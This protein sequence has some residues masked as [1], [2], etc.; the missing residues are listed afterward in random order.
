MKTSSV[1]NQ[2]KRGNDGKWRHS[3]GNATN[4]PVD[5]SESSPLTRRNF[6]GRVG[7]VATLAIAASSIPLEPLLDDKHSVAEAAVVGYDPAARAAAGHN[8]R[9]SRAEA[10]NI[11]VGVQP[12]NGDTLS[13]TDFSG[14]FSKGLQHD[15]LGVPNAASWLSLKYALQSGRHSDYEKIIV[16]T[17]GGGPNSRLNGPQGSLAF[18]LEGLDSHAVVI[19]PAP[20]VASAQTAAEAIE[21]YWGALLADIPFTQY[22]TNSL[23][24]Q[25]VRDMNKLS[26]VKPNSQYPFPVTPQNLFR[27]QFFDGDG[28]VLGPYISQFLVQPTFYGAQPLSQ[29]YQT[30]LPVG[31]GGSSFMTSVNEYQT[32]QNGGD[33]GRQLVFDST[34][35]FVRNGRDLAAYTHVDVLYQAY[36]VAF[37]VLAGIGAPPNP[38]NPYTHSAAEK[39]FATLGGPDV[40]GSIA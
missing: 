27:G 38:G 29:Q 18:D 35:R 20:S 7:G 26:A 40:A 12:D 25:A 2:K 21:H 36:F 39:A 5:Q 8:Y 14:S 32:V 3:N 24:A 19:P 23:V 16:G 33:S 15:G 37:L 4:V 10:D 13:F 34:F 28:N 11:N 31:N 9:T 30:F 22:P 6:L 1:S 17:P